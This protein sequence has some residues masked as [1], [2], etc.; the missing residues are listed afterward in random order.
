MGEMASEDCKIRSP[1]LLI[2]PEQ[3]KANMEC[4]RGEIE[5]FSDKSSS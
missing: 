3:L 5:G 1:R 4:Q 2:G